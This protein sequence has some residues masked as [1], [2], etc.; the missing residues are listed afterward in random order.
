METAMHGK[1]GNA[2]ML[3]ESPENHVTA[4]TR[5]QVATDILP[6]LTLALPVMLLLPFVSW[7]F[8]GF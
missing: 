7:F 4:E 6:C 5:K 1:G 2:P 8:G 3:A